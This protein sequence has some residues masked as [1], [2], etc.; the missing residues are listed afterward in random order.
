MFIFN[1]AYYCTSRTIIVLVLLYYC[2][3]VL[4][5]ASC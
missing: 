1:V 3:I 2:I 5:A 4:R